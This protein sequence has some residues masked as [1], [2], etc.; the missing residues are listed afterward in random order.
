MRG[1]KDRIENAAVHP[2]AFFLFQ[3]MRRPLTPA[4]DGC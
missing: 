2:A 3:V 4:G 1:G